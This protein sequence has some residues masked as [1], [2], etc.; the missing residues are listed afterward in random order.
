[1]SAP[2]RT[3]D[4]DRISARLAVV[5]TPIGNVGDVT[6][7][8]VDVLSVSDLIFCEDTRHTG[9]LLSRLGVEKR[10]LLSLNAHN[11][12]ARIATAIDALGRGD[13]IALVSDA[14]TPLVSDPGARLVGAVID[15]GYPVVAVPGP[16]A[17]LAALVVS[18][19]DTNRFAFFGFLPK[20]GKVRSERLAEIADAAVPSI[21][22]ESPRRVAATLA[23]LAALTGIGRR[24]VVARELTKL[25]EDVWRG[26]IGEALDAAQSAEPI[27]E[28]VLVIEGKSS[29]ETDEGSVRRSLSSLVEAGL[30]LV[31][32]GRA[33]EI[34]LG[35]PHRLGYAQRLALDRQSGAR[36]GKTPS[37]AR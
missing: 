7:R 21:V 27:G 24:V 11:E 19:F 13:D 8:A 35:A 2:S 25:F 5:S 26:P 9:L 6:R 37:R 30:S 1:V 15:A 36:G 14:G 33:V 18:G 17:A 29:G 12:A 34:L 31:D 22:F 4:N 28:H 16:S 3:R 23:D 32:A 10:P 20:S